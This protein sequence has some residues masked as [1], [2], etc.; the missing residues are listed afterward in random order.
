MMKKDE[1]SVNQGS[2]RRRSARPLTVPLTVF[3]LAVCSL[4]LVAWTWRVNEIRRNDV[5]LLATIG[6]IQTRAASFHLWLE[7]WVTDEAA[8]RAPS[9][10]DNVKNDIALALYFSEAVLDGG[11]RSAPEVEPLEDPTL[12]ARAASVRD[13]LRELRTVGEVRCRDPRLCGIGSALDDRFDKIFIDFQNQAST[14]KGLVEESTMRDEARSR[15]LSFAGLALW[16]VVSTVATAGLFRHQ[17]R[18]VAAE[19]AL[20]RANEELERRVRERTDSLEAAN[21]VLAQEVA[22]RRHAEDS[23]IEHQEQLRALS[24]QLTVAEVRERRRLATELHDRIGSVL[25]LCKIKLGG[26]LGPGVGEESDREAREGLRLLE[27][28]ITDTRTLTQEL[29]SPVLH[30]LGLEAGLSWLA[31]WITKEHKLPVVFESSGVP[32]AIPEAVAV[33]LFQAVRE[34]LVNVVKHARASCA[35]VTCEEDGGDIRITVKDDGVGFGTAAKD[36]FCSTRGSFGLFSVR[37]RLGSLGGY[38]EI[39]SG[40]QGTRVTLAAPSQLANGRI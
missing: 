36:P 1:D 25:A 29:C 35:W 15:H 33:L 27:Q 20:A 10:L 8:G 22:E 7:E 18:R 4:A 16:I 17:R 3:L 28:A 6:E 23:L 2:A 12:R 39:E 13:L 31:E 9:Y 26:A 21:A 38:I 34:L 32:R 14:F 30:E 37:E 5:I 40:E 24:S 11:R 19:A